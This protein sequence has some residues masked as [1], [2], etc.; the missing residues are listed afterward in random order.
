MTPEGR[1]SRLKGIVE[2]IN[3]RLASLESRVN[4][5]ITIT[6]AMWMTTMLAVLS[7]LAAVLL[8]T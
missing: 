6:V 3:Q 4:T 2:Q 5:Q 8:R 1:V 7:T